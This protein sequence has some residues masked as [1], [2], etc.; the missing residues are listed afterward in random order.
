MGLTSGAIAATLLVLTAGTACR[1]GTPDPAPLDTTNDTCAFCRMTVS[2]RR[3][4][5][6]IV[7][8][9]DEPL[10]FDDLGCLRSYLQ[11]HPLAH[12]AAVY[13]ADHRTA[14]WVPASRAV[15]SRLAPDSTPM[16]SG[17][18]AHAGSASREQDADADRST[19]VSAERALGRAASAERRP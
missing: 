5:A 4:A 6:E 13:V 12:D 16:G 9:D 3:L 1:R 18:I 14:E 8:P 15:F 19:P 10:F 17:L 7:A 11:D 2:D